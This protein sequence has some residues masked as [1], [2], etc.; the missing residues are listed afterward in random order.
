NVFLLRR[1]ENRPMPV[2][3][4]SINPSLGTGAGV[5]GLTLRINCE[6]PD[7]A[8]WGLVEQATLAIGIDAND[9]SLGSRAG[10]DRSVFGQSQ[11][12]N[13]SILAFIDNRNSSLLSD[14]K[15][16]T[17][18]ACGHVKVAARVFDNVPNMGRIETGQ[19]LKLSR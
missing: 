5:N 4:D 8:L 16:L 7:V 3:R 15:N 9:L 2:R 14:K 19:G 18:I 13:L 11:R 12:E 1:V 6:G 10:I 17:F